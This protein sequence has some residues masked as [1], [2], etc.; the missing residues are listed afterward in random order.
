[1]IKYGIYKQEIDPISSWV[2][3][4]QEPVS[5]STHAYPNIKL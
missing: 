3:S 4:V 5:V 2:N 1:M